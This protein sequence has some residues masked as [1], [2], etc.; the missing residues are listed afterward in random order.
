MIRR[1][2]STGEVKRGKQKR[3]KSH[4]PDC[5]GFPRQSGPENYILEVDFV[6]AAL[7]DFALAVLVDLVVDFVVCAKVAVVRPRMR[8]RP[9]AML[10]ILFIVLISP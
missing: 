1:N 8:P 4:G 7:V 5:P 10:A 6:L 3:G 2:A 9:R